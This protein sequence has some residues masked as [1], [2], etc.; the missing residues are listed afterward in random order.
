MAAFL[1]RRDM[2]AKDAAERALALDPKL[3][4]ARA[5]LGQALRRM[6]DLAGAIKQYEVVVAETDDR[7]ARS[8]LDRWRREAELHD[9][10]QHAFGAHFTVSFEGPSEEALATQ[11]LESLDRAY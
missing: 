7:D 1:E 2:E 8:T 4:N 5:L 6:G 3:A 9:R 10:M 11:A